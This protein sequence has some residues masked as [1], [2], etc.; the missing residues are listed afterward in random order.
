MGP[1]N[2]AHEPHD[3][4]ELFELKVQ[5]VGQQTELQGMNTL[6]IGRHLPLVI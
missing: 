1:M 4:I 3:M 2:S 5:V 6:T